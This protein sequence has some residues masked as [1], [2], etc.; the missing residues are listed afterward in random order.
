[1]VDDLGLADAIE[2]REPST[3]VAEHLTPQ[4]R[5]DMLVF[6]KVLIRDA[7][8]VSQ[9]AKMLQVEVWEKRG[10]K[11]EKDILQHCVQKLDFEL[12]MLRACLGR[13]EQMVEQD[14]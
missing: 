5:K 8:K 1:M 9:N 7:G 13:I 3:Y 10:V 4:A 11:V 12:F 14:G 2:V 6:L